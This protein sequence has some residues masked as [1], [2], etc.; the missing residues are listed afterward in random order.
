V[1]FPVFIELRRSRLLAGALCAM[2]GAAA[3]AFL[4]MP[5][6][7]IR[8]LVSEKTENRKTA[9]SVFRHRSGAERRK[10]I[11]LLSSIF[12]LLEL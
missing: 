10:F 1:R 7:L 2:H 5:W 9:R 12:Y 3:G 11:C 4:A 8:G 6:P